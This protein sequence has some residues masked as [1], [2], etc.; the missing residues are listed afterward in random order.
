MRELTGEEKDW[1]ISYC[2]E[3]ENSEL[4][5]AIGQI[6]PE[7][8]RKMVSAFV[9]E[10]GESVKTLDNTELCGFQGEP[11]KETKLEEKGLY[12][13]F[14]LKNQKNERLRLGVWGGGNLQVS[15]TAGKDLDRWDE[16]IKG[17]GYKLLSNDDWWWFETGDIQNVVLSTLK[18]KELRREKI[19][20]FTDIFM[21]LVKEF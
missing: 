4:A 15:M 13:L 1:L 3:P 2:M 17:M 21:R 7:L 12:P 10:L 20:Y 16:I 8:K 18:D 11:A 9:R 14:I 5:L 6:Q 19:A